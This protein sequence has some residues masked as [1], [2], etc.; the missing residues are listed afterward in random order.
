QRRNPDWQK[1]RAVLGSAREAFL[2][3][4]GQGLDEAEARNLIE[5]AQDLFAEAAFCAAQ[6]GDLEAALSLAGEGRAKMLAVALRLRALEL[7]ADQRQRLE[8]LRATIQVQERTVEAAHGL[9]RSAAF[10]KL[11]K[12]RT[13][14]LELVKRQA[15]ERSS[16]A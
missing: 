12:V 5:Q 7:P 16:S 14:L 9:E 1:A 3:L 2:I 13:D 11:A 10:D 8:D 6:L 4:F 15:E